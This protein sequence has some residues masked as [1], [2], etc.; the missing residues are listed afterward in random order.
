MFLL[1]IADVNRHFHLGKTLRETLR[2]TPWHDLLAFRVA[3]N[4]Q[5][6]LVERLRARQDD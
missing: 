5:A 6:V 4:A 2:E 3:M 1:W